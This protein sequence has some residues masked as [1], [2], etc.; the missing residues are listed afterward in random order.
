M[1]KMEDIC[2]STASVII[3]VRALDGL[4]NPTINM[5]ILAAHRYKR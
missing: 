2:S 5:L 1:E 3:F 4:S